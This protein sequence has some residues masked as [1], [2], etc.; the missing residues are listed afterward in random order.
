MN[1]LDRNTIESSINERII[2]KIQKNKR[3]NNN[4][5]QLTDQ[6]R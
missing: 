2:D 1:N 5:Q 6:R 4:S 3:L